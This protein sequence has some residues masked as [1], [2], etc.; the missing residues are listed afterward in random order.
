MSCPPSACD[1]GDLIHFLSDQ[2]PS[3]IDIVALVL[4]G[5]G[6]IASLFVGLAAWRTSAKATRIAEAAKTA[7]ETRDK[8]AY[9]GRLDDA[10]V[11]LFE[12]TGSYI[13][14]LSTRNQRVDREELNHP[15]VDPDEIAEANPLP[16]TA[17]LTVRMEAAQLVARGIDRAVL[18]KMNEH[19]VAIRKTRPTD[20]ELW[21]RR[22][23][24]NTRRW[25]TEEY[26]RSGFLAYL[27]DQT[28]RASAGARPPR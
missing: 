19:L 17:E 10:L 27:R 6:I 5:L 25:R 11:R 26:T 16:S 23:I 15:G 14:A 28:A 13:E 24:R 1:L 18:A 9:D 4:S 3:V 7:E 2:G 12:A 8:L 22:F 21:F 20:Q